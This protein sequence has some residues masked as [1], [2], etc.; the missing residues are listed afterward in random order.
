MYETPA[1]LPISSV[2][3]MPSDERISGAEAETPGL[4]SLDSTPRASA[5]TDE[6][7]TPFF[8]EPLQASGASATQDVAEAVGSGDTN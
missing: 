6:P 3:G 7:E 1:Q 8:I 2:T 4:D 5:G